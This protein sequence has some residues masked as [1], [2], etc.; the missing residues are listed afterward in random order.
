MSDQHY[1]PPARRRVH[2]P[3]QWDD[4]QGP[5]AHLEAL[6]KVRSCASCRHGAVGLFMGRTRASKSTIEVSCPMTGGLNKQ[7][8]T[9]G[10]WGWIAA[11]QAHARICT[12]YEP[13]EGQQD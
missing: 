7:I 9:Q 13:W 10:H 8:P 6:R 3:G 11:L 2:Y 5:Q 1:I 12:M 4:V